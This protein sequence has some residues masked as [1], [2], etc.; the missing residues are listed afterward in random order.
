MQLERVHIV[1]FSD[2]AIAG[3]LLARDHPSR[4]ASLVAI[5]ANLDPSGLVD[6]QEADPAESSRVDVM[7]RRD[8]DRLS[9][10][11]PEHATIVLEKLARLW[12]D[13]PRI[14]PETLA[15]IAVPTMIMTGDHDSIRIDHTVSIAAAIPDAQLCVIPGAR[16]EVMMERPELVNTILGDF[17]EA[18]EGQ[19]VKRGAG[20]R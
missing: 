5:G 12:A 4:V 16:H 17:L 19:R 6:E 9:P 8:Y 11:G 20:V 1:G 10:D 13:E 14:A 2:G 7:L 3:L 18:A 15:G